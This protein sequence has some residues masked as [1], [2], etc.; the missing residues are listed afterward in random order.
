MTNE[1]NFR[2]VPLMDYKLKFIGQDLICT[3]LWPKDEDYKKLVRHVMEDEEVAAS[4]V[5]SY[6]IATVLAAC[7]EFFQSK[8]E[9]QHPSLSLQ[10]LQAHPRQYARSS[11]L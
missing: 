9:D 6:Q 7:A 5:T 3:L 1:Y 11:G 2:L 4:E 8:D 10:P